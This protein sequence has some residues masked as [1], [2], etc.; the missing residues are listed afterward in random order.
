ME[1]KITCNNCGREYNAKILFCLT[2]GSNLD[3]PTPISD[4]SEISFK[5][6]IS[7]EYLDMYQKM[8]KELEISRD[9]PGKIKQQEMHLQSLEAKLQLVRTQEIEYGEKLENQKKKIE[10]LDKVNFN[11]FLQRIKGQSDEVKK[12]EEEN[13]LELLN[14]HEAFR[15][16]RGSIEQQYQQAKTEL[17][18]LKSFQKKRDDLEVQMIELIHR[19]THG[20]KDPKENQIELDISQLS[21]KIDPIAVIKSKYQTSY[22]YLQMAQ[23]ALREAT[24]MMDNQG[25]VVKQNTLLMDVL[26]RSEVSGIRDTVKSA[27]QFLDQAHVMLKD[28]IQDDDEHGLFEGAELWERFVRNFMTDLKSGFRSRDETKVQLSNGIADVNKV[29]SWVSSQ[30]GK[31]NYEIDLILDEI[32]DKEQDLLKE[33]RRIIEE[34]INSAQQ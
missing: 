19:A 25:E 7:P 9:F 5:E 11:S 13:Y 17:E 33:R 4:I 27:T 34:A 18:K 30:L 21:K 23:E 28:S 16:E 22:S 3:L 15:N 32:R 24:I 14:Q 8:T 2:C 1:G 20:I 26:T 10:S 29:M 12:N 6:E 31:I